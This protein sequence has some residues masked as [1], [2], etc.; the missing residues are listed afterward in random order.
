MQDAMNFFK[1]STDPTNY[2]SHNI[3][4][5]LVLRRTYPVFFHGKMLY[6]FFLESILLVKLC[7][8]M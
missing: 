6:I 1:E 2:P 3:F 8:I 4:P 5:V 7:S